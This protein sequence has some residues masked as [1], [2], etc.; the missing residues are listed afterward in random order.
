MTIAPVSF[1]NLQVAYGDSVILHGITA[2]IPAGQCVAV[3]GSNGSGKSTLLK[4]LLGISPVVGG[5]VELFGQS[6]RDQVPWKEIGYVPQRASGGGGIASTVKE[7]VRTGLLGPRKF[8][9]PRGSNAKV[10]NVLDNVGLRHRQGDAFKVLSGGQQQRALIARAL[11]REPDL[12]LLDEPLSGLDSHNR[13]TLARIIGD[14]KAQGKTSMIVLHE[15]GELA[16]LIDRELRISS[17]HLVHDGPCTHTT[18]DLYD[19]HH[20][21]ES[22]LPTYRDGLIGGTL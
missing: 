6:A 16:P 17:G 15:L 3:T 9:L 1:T 5:T 2:T 20:G 10:M 14:Y 8:W 13:E 11:V 7:V 18:H 4:A 21:P 12:L 22:E 19:H